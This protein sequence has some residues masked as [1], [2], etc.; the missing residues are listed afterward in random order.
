MDVTTEEYRTMVKGGTF[1]PNAVK[2]AETE[3]SGTES[4]RLFDDFVLLL[5]WP[6]S[7]NHRNGEVWSKRLNRSVK[8]NTKE[9][10]KY[11][12]DV[13]AVV[14]AHFA[15]RGIKCQSVYAP[16]K[17]DIRVTA[18]PP[19]RRRY[20]L[21]NTRKTLFDA[22]TEANL[23]DD[24]S[25]LVIPNEKWLWLEIVKGGRIAIMVRSLGARQMR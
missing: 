17:L 3:Q 20:D 22:L 19:N 23:W 14:W 6:P 15:K 16:G 1:N 10:Q 21:D 2:Q 7:G 18:F 4:R 25:N 8:Y 11:K 5:P 9:Y 13:G 24:D 12:D